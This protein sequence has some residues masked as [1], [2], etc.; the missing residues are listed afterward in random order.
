LVVERPRVF[1]LSPAR[2]DGARARMLFEPRT[3]FPIASALRSREGAPIGEV[4]A[5]LSGLYFRGKLA[6]AKRFARPP[7]TASWLGSG[8]L[9]ITQNRGLVPVESRV[10]LEHLEA[11]SATDIHPEERAFR[12]PFAR[13]AA[14][15][16]DS[17]GDEGDVVLLG[18]VASAKYVGVLTG[19]LGER[20]LFPSEFVGRGD[21]SRGGLLLR[22]VDAGVELAYAPVRGAKLR[23][24]RPPKL[25]PRGRAPGRRP[26]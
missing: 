18:S 6:Y 10:C 13:D 9:V 3:M 1:V 17:I 7:T 23:G 21:M 4:F 14:L 20:L 15:V 22:A 24:A 19:A 8:A 16:V 12:E 11:F 26:G 5:F 2:L 25:A